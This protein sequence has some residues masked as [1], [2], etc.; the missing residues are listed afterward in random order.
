MMLGKK[1]TGQTVIVATSSNI[2]VLTF[3]DRTDR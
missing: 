2:S 1:L 3:I